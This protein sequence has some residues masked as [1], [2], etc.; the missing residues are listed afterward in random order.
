MHIFPVEVTVFSTGLTTRLVGATVR[1]TAAKRAMPSS[2]AMPS[3]RVTAE[4]QRWAPSAKR[5]VPMAALNL[6]YQEELQ[7]AGARAIQPAKQ[8]P[9]RPDNRP[10]TFEEAR[11]R[12]HRSSI[13]PPSALPLTARREAD[14]GGDTL[15]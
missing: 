13:S 14:P 7:R 11:D 4:Q 1:A 8:A 12:P 5:A 2:T 3:L 6:G 10:P 9:A 15:N